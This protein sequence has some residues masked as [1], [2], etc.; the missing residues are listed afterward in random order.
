MSFLKLLPQ[1]YALEYIK[2]LQETDTPDISSMLNLIFQDLVNANTHIEV[3]KILLL[4]LRVDPSANFNH[5]IR[6]ASKLGHLELVK[7]L[8][9][10]SRVDPSALNNDAIAYASEFGHLEVVKLLLLDPRV[11]PSVSLD[12]AIRFGAKEGHLGVV[13]TLLLDRRVNP[14]KMNNFAIKSASKN[15]HLDIVKLLIPRVDLSRIT[16]KKILD[17]AKR[18]NEDKFKLAVRN[19]NLETVKTRLLD[20]DP[21]TDSNYAIRIASEYGH[22]EIVKLLLGDSKLIQVPIPIM[23]L[24]G[25]F[26]MATWKLLKFSYMIPE[27]IRVL[28]IISQLGSHRHMVI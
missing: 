22:L 20:T 5:A 4:D 7:I 11:D 3:I 18:M 6:F 19:G 13:E 26:K 27:S 1:E 28:I 17:I 25:L 12:Y 8:L 16:D 14:C 9:Y 2:N 10:D 24:D 23:Q 15:N 21:T